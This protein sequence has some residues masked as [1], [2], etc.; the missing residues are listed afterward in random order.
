MRDQIERKWTFSDIGRGLKNS[1]TAIIKGELMLRLNIGRYFVHI[2]YTF[3]LFTAV[4]WISLL[5]ESTMAK[6]EKNK[7]ILEDLRIENAQK[8]FDAESL[9]RRS[10]VE[11]NLGLM[12][13]DVKEPEKR[14][15]ILE[16]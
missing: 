14:A 3:V 11:H 5:V 15:V 12:G 10:A 6:V 7:K 16:K 8:S 4:I 13:S 2:V 1:F 9:M